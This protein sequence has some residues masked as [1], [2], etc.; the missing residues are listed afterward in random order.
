[1]D[2]AINLQAVYVTDLVGITILVVILATRGW[3][4]PARKDES[5]ILLG[6][7]LFSILNCIA[8]IYVFGCDGLP[9]LKYYYILL[10]GNSYLY[11]YNLIVGIGIIYLIIKH[12]DR[13]AK[14]WHI[15]LFWII[16]TTE[17][18][19]LIIN[20]FNPV[21]FRIDENNTYHRGPYYLL[22]V[23]IGFILIF[24]GYLY[25]LI[26]K[27]RNPSLR[28]FPVIGFLTPILLGNAIQMQSY[29]ISLL[30]ISFTV[31]FSAISISLQNE[32]IYIDK[33]TGVYNRYELDKVLKG[34][35][36]KRK[37]RIAALMLDLNDFKSINDEFSHEEGDNALVAFASI[38]SETIAAEGIVIRFAG[39]E[40]IILIPKFKGNDISIYKEQINANLE[41]YNE[42][43]SKP[44][45]LA[46]AIGGRIF[47]SRHDNMDDLVSQ[48]DSLMYSDKKAYYTDHDR[49]GRKH[50]SKKAAE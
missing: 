45:K 25:Y 39:D 22:F 32:C 40:F 7:L 12:I 26:N 8:D 43:S 3:N 37:I 42:T 34:H 36:F 48:I 17:A 4:L 28:Y 6:L 30:P 13:K 33:L 9:G 20:F 16:V 27:L 44:Y 38:L 31:A 35:I 41:K 47:D 19:L 11:F 2:T 49:R 46:A 14:G 1:M 23:I 50:H 5:H 10:I 21:V 24:Y 15:L 29:G 18:V